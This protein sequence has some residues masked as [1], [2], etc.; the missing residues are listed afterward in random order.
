MFEV[1]RS[2]H[3]WLVLMLIAVIIGIFS[4]ALIGVRNTTKVRQIP[5]ALINQDKGA[6]SR[7]VVRQLRH[8]FRGHDAKIKWVKAKKQGLNNQKYYAAVTIRPGFS[9]AIAKQNQRVKA[10]IV[11]EKLTQL[12]RTNQLPV[13]ANQQLIQAQAS[14][15]GSVPQ[16]KIK[17]AI[18]QGM[19]AQVAQL[20]TQALPKL[21]AQLTQQLT[22]KRQKLLTQN[23]VQ[24]SA[25]AWRQLSQPI[26]TS[27]H[28][29]NKI[30]KNTIS[31]MAP[32]LLV[33]LAWFSALI[34]SVLLWREHY[35]RNGSKALTGKA[36]TSQLLT[37]IVASVFLA[38]IG[39]LFVAGCFKLNVPDPFNF[40][41]LMSVSIFVFYLITTCILD[42]FGLYGWPIV[43]L[44][45]FFAI[46]VLSYAP[47]MLSTFARNGIYNWVPMRFSMQA[48]TNTLYFHGGSATTASALSVLTIFGTVAAVLMYGSGYCK[49]FVL[50]RIK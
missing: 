13:A 40:I 48:I 24:L 39:Y 4:F 20:L 31:G 32:M 17:I 42:W 43:L 7:K 50:A 28:T 11:A 49:R 35:R 46:G 41:G 33:A 1:I 5:V 10:Q 27:V 19:N 34:A 36:V 2:K 12:Q 22:Q 18:N 47:E 14:A 15:Q 23:Q 26:S 37:G 21:S 38:S 29:D 3:Y 45:W 6:F 25:S 9:Q 30:R 16:A 44:V 8:R